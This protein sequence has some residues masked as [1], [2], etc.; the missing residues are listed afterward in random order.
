[1]DSD[2]V[3]AD[4]IA[5]LADLA[6]LDEGSFRSVRDRLLAFTLCYDYGLRIG[7]AARL[8]TGD[9]RVNDFVEVVLRGEIQK[10]RGKQPVP[11]RNLFPE[12][13][14]LFDL[15]LRL[16]PEAGS[17]S[18]LLS[19][20]GKPMLA[21]GCR[22]AV[23]RVS[24]ELGI[25]THAGRTPS[26]HRYRHSLGTLNVGELGMRLSP[27]YLMRRYRH[28]DLKVTTQVYVANNPLLDEAQHLAVVNAAL[29]NG[30]AADSDPRPRAM[31][32]DITVPETE[33]MAR[34][35]SL[36]VTWRSLRDHATDE[37]AAVDRNGKHFYSE[38]FLERLCT[39]WITK[40]EAMRLMGIA[41][42]TAYHNR[43]RNHGI[44]TLVIGR[45]SLAKS[46]DVVRSLH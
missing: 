41:S 1:M 22:K 6:T 9:V 21:S 13:R 34:V 32:T 12:S 39:E 10:G 7:E 15:Y 20:A 45:A 43:V 30:H 42:S 18:L 35:R 2:Y 40:K 11:L 29:G 44:E 19:L 25:L 38:A 26:P 3:P 33:A 8:R 46:A 16:R 17:D 24:E 31:A 27:Y 14:K 5:K 23:K 4:Q 37:K 28:N 36:G